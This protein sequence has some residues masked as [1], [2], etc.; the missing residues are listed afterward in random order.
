MHFI[1]AVT[2]ITFQKDYDNKKIPLQGI[3]FIQ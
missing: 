1:T 3:E 2:V